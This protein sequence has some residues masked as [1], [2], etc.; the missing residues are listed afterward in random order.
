M[1]FITVPR[2]DEPVGLGRFWARSTILADQ[3]GRR[4]NRTGE[5]IGTAFTARDMASVADALDEDG[6]LRY[7]GEFG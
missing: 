6:Q 5:L 2:A 3:C 1:D 4:Q 7:W